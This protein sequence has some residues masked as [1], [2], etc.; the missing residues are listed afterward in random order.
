MATRTEKRELVKI[1]PWN[2][3]VSERNIVLVPRKWL[4]AVDAAV[5]FLCG[6]P[7][8]ATSRRRRDM[9]NAYMEQLI[10]IS[11]QG[12]SEQQFPHLF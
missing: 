11:E 9:W 5:P 12:E 10:E 2:R 3:F 4:Q 1:T 7:P 8:P 6:A